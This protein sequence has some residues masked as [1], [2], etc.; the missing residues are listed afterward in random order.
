MTVREL[1]AVLVV[2][3][4]AVGAAPA[5]V[6]IETPTGQNPAMSSPGT[7][8]QGGYS[9]PTTYSG[10][11]QGT[12]VQSG[13]STPMTYT[14]PGTIY[15]GNN[16]AVT[17]MTTYSTPPTYGTT[18][19]S[20]GTPVYTTY[21]TY[22]PRGTVSGSALAVPGFNNGFAN[23]GKAS[24]GFVGNVVNYPRNAARRIFRR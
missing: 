2:T 6:Y 9:A 22:A 24:T 5:Q 20:F 21:P 16:P 11:P 13:Y 3:A 18:V 14:Q 19:S 7:I 17:G 10:Y 15:Y 1:M 23:Y 4:G 12:I 8:F